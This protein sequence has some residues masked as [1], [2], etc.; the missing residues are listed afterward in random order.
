M[1]G[2]IGFDSTQAADSIRFLNDKV[3]ELAQGAKAPETLRRAVNNLGLSYKDLKDLSPE[4][5]F[6]DIL[7]AAQN[8]EDGQLAMSAASELLGRQSVKLVGFFRSQSMSVAELLE[9][10]AQMNL[11]TDEGREG[12]VRM[13]AAMDNLGAVMDS[14]GALFSGILG[15]TLSP[16][17]EKF[18]AWVAANRELIQQKLKEWA[19]KFGKVVDWLL[20]KLIWLG[21]K[22]KDVLT[23]VAKIV[24]SLGGFENAMK[25]VGIALT[26]AAI[27]KGILL[28]QRLGQAAVTTQLK[29]FAWV[30]VIAGILLLLDELY[31]FLEDPE[32]DTVTRR[33]LEAF[34]EWLGM[35][36]VKPI[37]EAWPA[38]KAFAKNL[39]DRFKVAFSLIIEGVGNLVL[40]FIEAFDE[41]LGPAWDKLMIRIRDSWEA[42]W[43]EAVQFFRDYFINPISSAFDW[44]DGKVKSIMDFAGRAA[45]FV[46]IS[47]AKFGG[48]VGAGAAATSAGAGATS[49]VANSMT[50]NV[51]AQTNASADSI[52]NAVRGKI[53]E[54]M[55]QT[56]NSTST[57]VER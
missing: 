30:A 35:D 31:K 23:F 24:K 39:W 16:L 36:L 10:Q 18:N 12:A 14:A 47:N 33:V 50:I 8:A 27:L 42:L 19:E 11:Q 2:A 25:L 52:G 13:A 43:P 3:G 21:Q 51:Q 57:G 1:L 55:G 32:A 26:S 20:P 49:N 46:G 22:I 17:I 41:G 40:F 56:V 5:Q 29:M 34:E 48:G 45:A 9:L 44:I 4:K 54:M 53:E 6:E 15:D 7:Q 37:R 28:I 38:I